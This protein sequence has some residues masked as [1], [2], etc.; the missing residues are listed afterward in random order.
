MPDHQKELTLAAIG[1]GNRTRTYIELAAEEPHRYQTVAAADPVV[2]RLEQARRLSRNPEFRSFRTAEDILSEPKLADVM[3]VGSQDQF[4]KEHAVA[5]ME[6]G[7]DLLLE[8][9]VATTPEDTLAVEQTAKHLGR[10]VLV[11]HVLRY[12]PFYRKVKEIVS[13]GQLGRVMSLN[14]TEGVGPWHFAHSYVRGHWSVI[15]RSSP[16]VLAKCSHDLDIIR[17]LMAA[18]CKEVSSFGSLTHFTAANLPDGA[19]AHCLE[20]CPVGEHCAYN[21]ERYF[22]D[23]NKWLANVC[24]ATE[25]AEQRKW[26]RHSPWGRCVYRSDNDAVDHQTVNMKFSNESTATLIM[27]AFE[28]GRHIEIFGTHARLRG[29][30]FV[31][32]ACGSD[33]VVNSLDGSGREERLNTTAESGGYDGHLGGDRAFVRGLYDEMKRNDRSRMTSS[34]EASIDSH[35]MAFAAERARLEGSVVRM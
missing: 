21:A 28:I 33:I 14:A 27:T 20:G 18:S 16:M 26:L 19:P 22:S 35:R 34:L 9:P 13:D 12:T 1:C 11:C 6:A 25:E 23:Q 29:G 17:W 3:I 8:K 4:H 24:D 5:S 7:Y 2:A 31:R 10:R 32:Q 15:S 30:D